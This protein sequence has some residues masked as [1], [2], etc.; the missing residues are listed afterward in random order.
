M[1]L[2]S[3]NELLR[4]EK[5]LLFTYSAC[6]TFQ[7]TCTFRRLVTTNPVS[8]LSRFKA[9]RNSNRVSA[10]EG[11]CKE[12]AGCA[13]VYERVLNNIIFIIIDAYTGVMLRYWSLG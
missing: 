11:N 6:L 2:H 8:S 7:K 5:S 1:H 10:V 3:V 13:E 12:G 4:N 9:L